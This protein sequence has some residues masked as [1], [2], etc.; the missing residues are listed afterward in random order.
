VRTGPGTTTWTTPPYAHTHIA[1]WASTGR[2]PTTVR[3]AAGVHVP[4]V[5]GMHG[6]GVSTPSAAAVAAATWGLASDVHIA[7]V[8]TFTR[9]AASVTVATGRPS[10]STR[11]VGS[12]TSVAG[13]VP[14]EQLTVA[15]VVTG[16]GTSQRPDPAT[17]AV[18]GSPV[19]VTRQ[20]TVVS[21]SDQPR[22]DGSRYVRKR[23]ESR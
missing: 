7:K 5:A 16:S 13:A 19:V 23:S 18:R 9:G 22:V 2:P 12:A 15:D 4:V 17:D 6:I 8:A 20:V 3:G 14:N 11:G 10:T 21:P 1:P